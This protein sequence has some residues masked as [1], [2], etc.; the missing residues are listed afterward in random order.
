MTFAMLAGEA[1]GDNLGASLMRQLKKQVP[2]CSF[3]GVGGPA[4][5]DEGMVS[6]IDMERLSVNG[7]IDPF[8]RLPEL[9]RLLWRIRDRV[10]ESKADCFV[11]VDFNF[12]NLLLA[13]I[14]RKRG[15]K[16]IQYVSPTVW[17]WR[18]GRIN[19]IKRNVDLMMTLYPFENEIYEQHGVP[20]AFVGHPKAAEIS[21]GEGIEGKS[22]A[23]VKLD[24][25]PDAR[26]VAMLPGSR[27]S[28]VNLTGRDFLKAALLLKDRVDSFL[29][30]AANEKRM[31]QI[32][33][34]LVEYPELETLVVTRV[35]EARTM[36]T[37]ADVVLVNSGTATLEAML[38]RKPMV[39]SYRLGPLTYALVS[40]LVK[41]SWF[42]LP[43]ILAEELLV[44]ELIQDD[45][46]P[47]RLAEEVKILLDSENNR[48]LISRFDE[49]HS[50]L[51]KDESEAARVVLGLC[52]VN[53]QN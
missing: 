41:T 49:I 10:I 37:A 45:A 8:L 16:T 20:V 11:G 46:D 14:L 36:M 32:K 39:M 17:A 35:G 29:V 4:M 7:F 51:R 26:V 25:N 3:V 48:G 33:S 47:A 44:P 13:G 19:K 2:D 18:S 23:R 6:E 53:V 22:S 27:G 42:A 30:P 1:S 38:L 52:G 43:N 21:P 15:I 34:M 5:L 12:F 28:E 50:L 24:I 40:R 31:S 9:I